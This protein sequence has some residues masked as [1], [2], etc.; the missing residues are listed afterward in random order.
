MKHIFKIGDGMSIENSTAE[1]RKEIWQLLISKG[2]KFKNEEEISYLSEW[3]FMLYFDET[4]IAS[5]SNPINPLTYS[6]MKALIL[7]DTSKMPFKAACEAIK[8]GTHQ[9]EKDCNNLDLLRDVLKEAFPEHAMLEVYLNEKISRGDIVFKRHYARLKE[10]AIHYYGVDLPIIK[11]SEIMPKEVNVPLMAVDAAIKALKVKPD[12][13]EETLIQ[14]SERL[15]YD[16]QELVKENKEL[17]SQRD[18]IGRDIPTLT[19]KEAEEQL[20][21]KIVD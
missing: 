7:G 6:Q 4:F 20:N 16:L 11:L 10:L 1:E 14:K 15:V 13:Y 8:H 17:I 18:C 9:I 19:R 21:V 5:N 2:Y 3:G 12:N